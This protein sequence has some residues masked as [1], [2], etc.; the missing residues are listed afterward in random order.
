MLTSPPSASSILALATT[1][2]FGLAML[3]NH[4]S[5]AAMPVSPLTFVSLAHSALPWVLPSLPG[6]VL[7]FAIHGVW[8]AVC[9]RLVP[10]PTS[11]VPRVPDRSPDPSRRNFVQVPVLAVVDETADIKTIRVAR[12]KG[13]DF[14]AGQF[15]TV[16]V[17]VDGKDYARCYSISSAPAVREYLEISVKRQGLVSNALHAAV[18]P[19]AALAMRSPAGAFRYPSGDDRPILL[20]AGGIGITPLMSMLRHAL[21]KEP[22]RPVTLI[23]S[24]QTEADFAFLDEIES[25]ARRHPQLRVQLAASR[26]STR[27]WV[28]PGRIDEALL[29]ATAPAAAESVAF[30]CGPAVMIDS[31]K[32]LLAQLGVPPAQVRHEIFQQAIAASAGHAAARAGIR[33]IDRSAA[34]CRMVC[35]RAGK[36]VAISR[37]QTILEAAEAGGVAIDSLCRSGVCGTCRVRISGGDVDCESDALSADE[38]SDGF[39]LAC[40]TIASSNCTVD[41]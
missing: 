12:P 5:P 1:A 32:A 3:R 34:A 18:R 29:R 6:L 20:V 9:E 16:R 27:P 40:V 7:G 11:R 37:G 24:V 13:F 22:H 17:R 26:S 25:A 21:A 36:E 19:G 10:K 39:V 38:R 28:Y 33:S 14:E 15:V 35:S 2:H 8:F 30:V 4:R 31:M 23:Y 41:L